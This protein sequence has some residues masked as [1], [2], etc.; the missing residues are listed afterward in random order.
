MK[1]IKVTERAN[2]NQNLDHR[3][4]FRRLI[5]QMLMLTFTV[6][7]MILYR[8]R[9]QKRSF[10]FHRFTIHA[11]DD[12]VSGQCTTTANRETRVYR[13]VDTDCAWASFVVSDRSFFLFRFGQRLRLTTQITPS[14]EK[15]PS[16]AF[17]A[18]IRRINSESVCCL[19]RARTIEIDSV[20]RTT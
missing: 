10:R 3:A 5:K 12:G 4:A 15:F 1:L 7:V 11:S 9:S 13:R 20:V 6:D 17:K 14:V 16:T 8:R 19:H 2:A 18:D